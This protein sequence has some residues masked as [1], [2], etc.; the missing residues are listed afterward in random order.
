MLAKAITCV[1]VGVKG[2][3]VEVE[4]DIAQCL[5]FFAIVGL[6]D[7][8]VQEARERAHPAIRNSGCIFP[9]KRIT[10]TLAPADPEQERPM[11]PMGNLVSERTGCSGTREW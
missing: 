3:I 5:P 8:A 4:E 7:T 6:P 10:V 11:L 9:L 1:V 2:A